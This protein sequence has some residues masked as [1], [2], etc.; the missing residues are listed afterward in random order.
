MNVEAGHCSQSKDFM[1]IKFDIDTCVKLG[2]ASVF[3]LC[4]FTRICL[5]IFQKDLWLD[6]AALVQAI[7]LSGWQDL[8]SGKLLNNQSAPLLFVLINKGILSYS[9]TPTTLIY[10]LPFICSLTSVIILFL[11]SRKVGDLFYVFSVMLIFS[12]CFTATY[13]AGEF[14]PYSTDI[15]ISLVLLYVTINTMKGSV[16]GF[17][18]LKNIT[19]FFIC[20]LASSTAA[21]YVA[22]ILGAELIIAW[23][24]G[25]LRKLFVSWWKMLLLLFL[26]C[27]YYCLY[28]KS[29]NS[30]A[31]RGYWKPYFIPLSWEALL[32]YGKTAA[33]I[34]EA[35]FYTSR[36][37][38]P[39]L[40]LG[41][42][43][44]SVLIWHK[45]REYF[46]LLSFPVLVTVCTNLFF[47]PPGHGGAPHGG[48]LLLFLLPNG[49]LVIAWFYAWIL[50]KIAS[51]IDP[52]CG[53]SKQVSRMPQCAGKIIFISML[54]AIIGASLWTNGRYLWSNEYYFQ[55]TRELIRIMQANHTVE[56][57]TLIYGPAYHAYAYYKPGNL[58]HEIQVLP[59]DFV[60]LKT[61]LQELPKNRRI[62]IL[63]SHYFR[64]GERG[65]KEIEV[66]FAAEGRDFLKIPAKGAVLYILLKRD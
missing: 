19:L 56:T 55:Q 60:Q 9:G 20:V 47:Y 42:I 2:I 6:E 14:K 10:I 59:L 49:V 48:R 53:M 33:A 61:R 50:R 41:L 12:F 7:N 39:L 22:G 17:W 45:R 25:A 13:Y 11:V 3:L 21:I 62:F 29:G 36:E 35:L 38:S 4:I 23:R 5:F 37:M 52:V 8:L 44:G 32:G 31:M 57:L 18:S 28:L 27:T 58:N 40:I 64:I 26:I 24:R 65:L 66:F 15:C 34:F 1:S 46:L 43:G 16:S 54:L 30:E 63:F 51:L